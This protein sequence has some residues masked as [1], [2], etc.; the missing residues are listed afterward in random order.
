M[1]LTE[2]EYICPFL[3]L[4][5]APEDAGAGRVFPAYKTCLKNMQAKACRNSNNY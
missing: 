1:E 3:T 4:A 5:S 2:Q